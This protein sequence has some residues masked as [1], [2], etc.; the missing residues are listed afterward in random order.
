MIRQITVKNL[1]RTASVA[2][3]GR[4]EERRLKENAG[5]T[6]RETNVKTL[7]R[8][9]SVVGGRSRPSKAV[10]QHQ[11]GAVHVKGDAQNNSAACWLTVLCIALY[12]S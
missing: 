6:I 7:P 8:I 9:A 2:G 3:G 12:W 11:P 4:D 5:A 10:P 1:V